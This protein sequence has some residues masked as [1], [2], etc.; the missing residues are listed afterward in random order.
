[1]PIDAVPGLRQPP[2]FSSKVTLS[3]TIDRLP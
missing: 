3:I 2:D 1:L